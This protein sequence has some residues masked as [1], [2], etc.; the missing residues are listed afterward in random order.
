MKDKVEK[1]FFSGAGY[2]T[3]TGGFWGRSLSLPGPS[4]IAR[5]TCLG[6]LALCIL[7]GISA[8]AIHTTLGSDV[9][10]SGISYGSSNVY[11]FVTGPNLP[12]EG[13]ALNN[14]AAG[15]GMTRVSVDVDGSWS[16]D[17]DTHALP[18]DAGSYT[19]WVVDA[20][21]GRTEL[22]GHDYATITVTFSRPYVSVSAPVLPGSLEIHAIPDNSSVVVGGQYRGMTP[23]TLRDLSP[24]SYTVTVSHFGYKP[25]TRSVAVEAG[26]TTV[27]NV[28]LAPQTGGLRIVTSPNAA[29]IH[30][31]G[32]DAGISPLTLQDIAVGNHTVVAHQ[33]GYRTTEQA[34]SVPA[35]QIA[36][37]SLTLL[38]S[39]PAPSAT[40]AGNAGTPVLLA[41]MAGIAGYAILRRM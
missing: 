10:L 38:P 22:A 20:P 19:V 1:G 14:V 28:T 7:S 15:G 5:A 37:V 36:N 6:L 31:D 40:Q 27:M 39:T 35:G 9:H 29:R 2:T 34:V 24:A 32:R 16:Y 33:E 26:S 3:E 30:I 25:S 23:L 8:A 41:I 12:P 17:W 13:A 11:L 18:L 4:G 21:V